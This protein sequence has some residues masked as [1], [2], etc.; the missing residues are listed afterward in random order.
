MSEL[1]ADR[2]S[3]APLPTAQPSFSD[4]LDLYNTKVWIKADRWTN[5]SP[6]DN[7][8]RA[9]HI[10]HSGGAMTITLDNKAF[11][12]EPYS[13]REYRTRGFYG[14]GCYEARFKPI[15]RDGAEH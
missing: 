14:Y 10:A 1:N 11:L 15:K 5:G 7:A 4:P 2:E 13:S 12:G 3:T 8:W 9:D 6:F